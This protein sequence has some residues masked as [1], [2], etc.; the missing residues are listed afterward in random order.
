MVDCHHSVDSCLAT[1]HHVMRHPLEA[2]NASCVLR[3]AKTV[4]WFETWINTEDTPDCG[5]ICTVCVDAR[6]VCFGT[7][8]R[9][10]HIGDLGKIPKRGNVFE[11]ADEKRGQIL[12]EEPESV[13]SQKPETD[14]KVDEELLELER[15]EKVQEFGRKPNYTS[16]ECSV[17]DVHQGNIHFDEGVYRR[18]LA[19]A[20]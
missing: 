19:R 16:I 13:G 14:L 17:R 1:S 20:C 15:G 10:L 5:D 9:D 12:N 7:E 3:D 8:H 18:S 2:K 11:Q 4:K 6:M